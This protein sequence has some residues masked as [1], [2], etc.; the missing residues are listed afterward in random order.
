MIQATDGNFYGTTV[1]GGSLFNGTV[2]QL[3]PAGVRPFW[4]LFCTWL[5]EGKTKMKNTHQQ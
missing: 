3:T 4:R 2:F 1:S 5:S